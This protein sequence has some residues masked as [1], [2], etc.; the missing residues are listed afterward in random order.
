[1]YWDEELKMYYLMTRYYDPKTGR[2]I[3]ADTPDYL[4]PETL[5]GLNLYAYCRNNPVIYVYNILFAEF[6]FK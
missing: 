3:N 1:M 4:D 6:C 2:F 5:G